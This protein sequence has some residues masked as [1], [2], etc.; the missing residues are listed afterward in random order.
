MITE[1]DRDFFSPGLLPTLALAKSEAQK[2]REIEVSQRGFIDKLEVV[3]KSVNADLQLYSPVFSTAHQ[4]NNLSETNEEIVNGEPY[5]NPADPDYVAMAQDAYLD[6]YLRARTDGEWHRIDERVKYEKRLREQE[7]SWWAAPVSLVGI[8][9]TDPGS[10]FP[11]A[12]VLKASNVISGFGRGF[13]KAIPGALAGGAISEGLQLATQE[14]QTVEESAAALGIQTVLGAVLGGGAGV[15][16]AKKAEK[17]AFTRIAKETLAGNDVRVQLDADGK[18]VGL[19]IYNT[20]TGAGSVGAAETLPL[21]YKGDRLVGANPDT[22][23]YSPGNPFF[24]FGGRV[25]RDP[26]VRAL[27]SPS[28]AVAQ[29]GNEI[30]EHSYDLVKTLAGEN[31]PA[32]MQTRVRKYETESLKASLEISDSYLEYIGLDPNSPKLSELQK[33][34]MKQNP[35]LL[36]EADFRREM[37]IAAV[38]DSY[39]GDPFIK[40]AADKLYKKYVQPLQDALGADGIIDPNGPFG[41]DRWLGRLTDKEYIINN[42]LKVEAFYKQQYI[43]VN[44]QIS[45]MLRHTNGLKEQIEGLQDAIKGAKDASVKAAH[46]AQLGKLKAALEAEDLR[47]KEDIKNNK[48]S[49]ELL[50][51]EGDKRRLRRILDDSELTISA[52]NTVKNRLSS[53]VTQLANDLVGVSRGGANGLTDTSRRV[54]MIPDKLLYENRVLVGD[55]D[56]VMRSAIREAGQMLEWNRYLK[57]KGWDGTGTHLDFLAHSIDADYDRLF[58]NASSKYG[59]T[60]E[61]VA[62]KEQAYTIKKPP[63]DPKDAAKLNKEIAKLERSKK[64]DVDNIQDMYRR[65][66]NTYDRDDETLIR[67]SRIF[68]NAAAGS[69]LGNLLFTMLGDTVAATYRIGVGRYIDG[70]VIPSIKSFIGASSISSKSLRNQ[71]ADIGKGL[72]LEASIRQQNIGLA[73]EGELPMSK[74][75]RFTARSAQ[76]MS[77]ANFSAPVSDTLNRVCVTAVTSSFIR[78]VVAIKAGTL[79]KNRIANLALHGLTDKQLIDDIVAANAKYGQSDGGAFL[80][81]LS[82][83]TETEGEIRAAV[84]M[85]YAV[86]KGVRSV[87]FSGADASSFPSGVD[88]KGRMRAL[89]LFMGWGFQ[90][91]QKFFLPLVQRM[92]PTKAIG[93]AAMISMSMFTEPLRQISKGEEPDLDGTHIFTKGILNSGT[94]GVMLD[95]FNKA[96]AVAQIFPDLIIDKYKDRGIEIAGGYPA[97]FARSVFEMAGGAVTGESNIADTRRAMKLVPLLGAIAFRPVVNEFIESLDLPETRAKARAQNE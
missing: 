28:P 26:V 87:I 13:V 93:T 2:Q 4:L 38:D 42:R 95:W 37:A 67:V 66:T 29:F 10:Y 82:K 64:E 40:S 94:L 31:L 75:E 61:K 53:N 5:I 39:A 83:W 34:L 89:F 36:T 25:L 52:Q 47:I 7:H 85:Q 74:V 88:P 90:A 3:N 60:I 41:A 68:N 78:D 24:W 55:I 80:P 76:L 44:E 46:E 9:I 32:A 73:V 54:D 43:Q 62:G 65:Q 81:N 8:G 72:E 92:D 17:E 15:Y 1:D 69:Q 70:G 35:N 96:N 50:V 30:L 12:S 56:V 59:A 51:G 11:V 14:T 48:I 27:K 84:A 71:A 45:D 57:S 79:S 97:A 33:K 21:D 77:I 19:N 23:W 63:A 91:N 22:P 49:P 58:A 6:R 86:D 20:N 18:P 16:V